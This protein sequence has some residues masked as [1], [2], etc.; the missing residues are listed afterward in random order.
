METPIESSKPGRKKKQSKQPDQ[1]K[2]IW[3]IQNILPYI[4]LVVGI[5]SIVSY[6]QGRINS[7]QINNQQYELNSINY[8][9]QLEVSCQLTNIQFKYIDPNYKT[10][11]RLDTIGQGPRAQFSAHIDI[12]IKNIGK[13]TARILML[14][15]SDYSQGAHLYRG[16]KSVPFV[17]EF[18]QN[19]NREFWPDKQINPQEVFHRNLESRYSYYTFPQYYTLHVWIVYKNDLGMIYDTYYWN[20]ARI[21]DSITGSQTNPVIVKMTKPASE[22]NFR[23]YTRKE[24]EL[25]T[26]KLKKW[27]TC[28]CCY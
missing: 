20:N 2:S 7:S 11:E 3:S 23:L 12:S 1:K 13:V 4:T 14:A 24:S 26:E 27:V 21:I 17:P 15:F 9:P 18:F 10:Y 22:N 8:S 6:V 5:I 19:A 28:C 25:I 16:L